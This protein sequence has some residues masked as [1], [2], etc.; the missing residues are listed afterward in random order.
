MKLK[1]RKTDAG[2]AIQ[3]KEG[4]QGNERDQLDECMFFMIPV[5]L[6]KLDFL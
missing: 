4:V 5:Q 2:H 3:R 6:P 1:G